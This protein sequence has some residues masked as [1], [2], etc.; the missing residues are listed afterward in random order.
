MGDAD[1]AELVNEAGKV[2]FAGIHENQPRDWTQDD[3]SDSSAERHDGSDDEILSKVK[4]TGEEWERGGKEDLKQDVRQMQASADDDD[5]LHSLRQERVYVDEEGALR[6][7]KQVRAFVDEEDALLGV[8]QE[9]VYNYDE[10]VLH[11]LRH[12]EILPGE[13]DIRFAELKDGKVDG[14]SGGRNAVGPGGRSPR[15]T[16]LSISS[17]DRSSRDSESESSL[18]DLEPWPD[19]AASLRDLITGPPGPQPYSA[20]QKE[21]ATELL[22]GTTTH[23]DTAVL[24]RFGN[25]EEEEEEEEDERNWE[26]EQERIQAFYRYYNDDDEEENGTGAQGQSGR[27]LMVRFCL[28]PPPQQDSDSSDTDADVV[29]SSSEGTDDLEPEVIHMGTGL[30]DLDSA[31]TGMEDLGPIET[32]LFARTEVDEERDSNREKFSLL[33][34]QSQVTQS[35][36]TKLNAEL[37]ARRQRKTEPSMLRSAMK[38]C[39]VSVLGVIMFWWA[40]DQLDWT[41]GTIK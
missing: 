26:Q 41:M 30:E 32:R 10:D 35:E 29:S 8:R 5:L 13:V 20:S 33:L 39:L 25:M 38:M 17:S 15:M 11:G 34:Q 40:T 16:T 7:I 28:D 4:F 1:E 6:C 2:E 31:V 12:E 27:K 14:S 36:L 3:G 21:G 37:R 18:S 23:I 9:Q 22:P 19:R 24:Q